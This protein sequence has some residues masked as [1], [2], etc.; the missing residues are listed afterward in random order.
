MKTQGILLGK[1]LNIPVNVDYSWFLIFIL[2]TWSLAISYYPSEFKQW[3]TSWY[4]I[5]GAITTIMLFISVLLHELGHSFVAL[6]YKIPVR[7][8]TLFIFGGVAQISSEPP[9]AMSEFWIA[10]AG[11]VVSFLLAGLFALL[12]LIVSSLT[13]LFALMKYLAYIN[14]TLGLFNL[15]PGFPLDGGRV[16]RAILWGASR[17]FRKATRIA[18]GVGR[19]IAYIFILVGVYFIFSGN[20]SGGI[21]IA[22]IGWFLEN[23][24]QSQRQQMAMRDLLS[25][26]TVS[27][28]MS[29]N[30]AIISPTI[31]LQRLADT[32]I[33]GEGRRFF[34]VQDENRVRGVL[35]LQTIR[36]IP[37]DQWLNMP[38]EQAM[39]QA[40]DMQW[41]RP[42]SELWDA[43]E[44]MDQNGVNQLPVIQDNQIAGLLTRENI[45]SFLRTLQE[46]K[47][48]PWPD[49]PNRQP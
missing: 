21:W 45:I 2:L 28:A 38:A 35:T 41:V 42:E 46:F 12:E 7:N 16:F 5:L 29:Q 15:I 11:P 9:T 30:Y 22:F 43:L 48:R 23:A 25:G 10:I 47:S 1:I 4:W 32:H 3:P 44:R 17:D 8:I 39:I 33:L 31:T 18:T 24:A 49:A 26:R 20:L 34:I 37:R 19:A 27:Q 14:G 36:Q 13:P 40:G 6:R